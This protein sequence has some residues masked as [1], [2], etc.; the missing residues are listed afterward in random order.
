MPADPSADALRRRLEMVEHGEEIAGIG[1]WDWDV[2]TGKLRWSDNLFRL[3]GVDPGSIDPTLEYVLE[4]THPA[5]RERLRQV[6]ET[7]ALTGGLGV[8]EYRIIRADGAARRLH[9]TVAKV[10]KEAGGV[11]FVGIVQDVTERRQMA[12]EIAV[13]IAL[14]EVLSTWT[15]LDR[16]AERLVSRLAE[17]LDFAVGILWVHRA[18]VLEVRS[19]WQAEGMVLTGIDERRRL[20]HPAEPHAIPVGA[21][22]TRR[23]AIV[24][25]LEHAPAFPGQEAALRAGL[26]AAVALPALSADAVPAVLEFYSRFTLEPS[27]TLSRTLNGMSHE[28]GHFFARRRAEFR[29]P[30]LTAREREILQLTAR[31]LSGKLIARSLSLSPST[32]KTHFENIYAKWGV[33]DRASAV[34]KALREG[35]IE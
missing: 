32:V 16:D 3:F 28:L 1:S 34:A 22:L 35:L 21:W 26:K 33:S 6:V 29:P 27:T 30:E 10:Q 23:P 31:G 7:A 13:H 4:R 5:D 15:S 25:S 14:E 2:V 12:R 18:D 9:S 19:I 8:V 24:A 20:L 11:R 17:A